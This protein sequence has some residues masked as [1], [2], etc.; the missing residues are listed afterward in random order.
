MLGGHQNPGSSSI[1]SRQPDIPGSSQGESFTEH[2]KLL[3]TAG[4]STDHM[5]SSQMVAD[6]AS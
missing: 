1:D 6:A 4:R 3:W 2:V 5:Y